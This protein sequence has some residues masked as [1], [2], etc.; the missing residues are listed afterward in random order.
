LGPSTPEVPEPVALQHKSV[1]DKSSPDKQGIVDKG[2]L[3]RG[4]EMP[5]NLNKAVAGIQHFRY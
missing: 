2:Q 4:H 3:G 5:H 1:G